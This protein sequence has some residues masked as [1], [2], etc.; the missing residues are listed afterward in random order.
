MNVTDYSLTEDQLNSLE[1]ALVSSGWAKKY[2]DFVPA[3]E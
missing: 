3:D 1:E 2:D